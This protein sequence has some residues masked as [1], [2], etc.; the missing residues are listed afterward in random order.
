MACALT[1]LESLIGVISCASQDKFDQYCTGSGIGTQ[2]QH[3]AAFGHDSGN[4]HASQTF[5]D[6]DLN[7]WSQ[8]AP[9]NWSLPYPGVS[10]EAHV[11][12]AAQAEA[13]SDHSALVEPNI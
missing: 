3:V 1:V 10:G 6:P 8:L 2:E 11:I 7:V 9:G 13:A 12:A 4:C 5:F